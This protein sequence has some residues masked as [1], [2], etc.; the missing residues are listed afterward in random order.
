MEETENIVL[1][2]VRDV[3]PAGEAC[4]AQKSKSLKE[5]LVDHNLLDDFLFYAD[6]DPKAF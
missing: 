5:V 6:A 1:P 2:E 3:T 4:S